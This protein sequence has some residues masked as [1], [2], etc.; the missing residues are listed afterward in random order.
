MSTDWNDRD[1]TEWA[2]KTLPEFLLVCMQDSSD[3]KFSKVKTPWMGLEV[4]V[5]EAQVDGDAHLIGK[6]ANSMLQFDLDLGMRVDVER[7]TLHRDDE[8]DEGPPVGGR[9]K[10]KK[11]DVEYWPFVAQVVHFENL[12][13]T[14]Q[15]IVQFKE[16]PDDVAKEVEWFI[17]EGMGRKYIWHGLA[18]WHSY[19]VKKWLKSEPEPIE[20]PFLNP[21]PIP[22]FPPFLEDERRRHLESVCNL[23]LGLEDSADGSAALPSA[24]K[25]ALAPKSAWEALANETEQEKQLAV[26]QK[27]S[28]VKQSWATQC[29]VSRRETGL[30]ESAYTS[31]P[32]SDDEEDDYDPSQPWEFNE[33]TFEKQRR[34]AA[35][36]L[37]KLG[38]FPF[39]PS[40]LSGIGGPATDW[41]RP[42]EYAI[43][44]PEWSQSKVANK[45][46]EETGITHLDMLLEQAR[47]RREDFERLAAGRQVAIRAG[48]L[49]DALD[50][51]DIM[52]AFSKLDE[53]SAS[54]PH[55]DT[56]RC[57]AHCC[58]AKNSKELLQMVIEA[59]ADLNARDSFGQTAL[60]MAAKQGSIEL[61]KVL[62]DAG[63]DA[64]VQDSLGRSAADMVKVLPIAEDHPLKN[65][66]E[67][68]YG[69]QIP[70]D[71]G[72]KS[73]DLKSLIDEKERPKKHGQMLL[74]AIAQK[75]ARTAAAAIDAG[76]DVN[77]CDERGDSV[78]V[79]LAKAK[80]KDI[81]GVQARL[82][83]KA[84]AA[85]ASVNCKNVQGNTPLHFAANRGDGSI[86]EA[87]LKSRADP[88]LANSEGNTP[89]MYAANGGHQ[90]VVKALLEAAAPPGAKS[91]TGLT[92]GEMAKRRGHKSCAQLIEDYQKGKQVP[93]SKV[94]KGR[95]FDYSKWD[96]LEREMQEDEEEELA[97]R[98]R[99]NVAANR[100]AGPKLEDLGPEAFGLP[101]DTPWPPVDPTNRRKGPFDYSHWDKIV[102]DIER[103]EH[104]VDRFDQLQKNPRYE[105]RNGEKM[106]V[107]Y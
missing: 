56:G 102:D 45:E 12:N 80:W 27:A 60:M 83:E 98:Q 32:V 31:P 20:D 35:P 105:M 30:E 89:L 26:A 72:K 40:M 57:A 42:K 52:K 43:G 7:R 106:R 17:R 100:R 16:V 46:G 97:V 4:C 2:K 96:A 10:K 68:M 38:R 86:C 92:A 55:P 91:S 65:W 85:G 99:E 19:A 104:I 66:R 103:H 15:L 62:L 81:E 39:L 64:T 44:H 37:K 51:G 95:A 48:E 59:K 21:E 24:A 14:P 25:P 58:V 33:E 88:A 76:G 18:R 101:P 53:E 107:V 9:P 73:Q 50:K 94:K 13:M 6:K 67:K 41:L 11:E 23:L 87:L 61:S 5:A 77:I 63:A 3:K 22:E 79:L 74:A 29:L 84:A 54:T 93:A 90:A 71:P 69:E 28:A 34:G 75:D 47:K 36:K 1:L 8:E 78:M 82:V 70:E 49:C